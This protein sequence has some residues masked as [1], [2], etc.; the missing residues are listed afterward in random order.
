[1]PTEQ[2]SFLESLR[3]KQRLL[4]FIAWVLYSCLRFTW[5]IT[6]I[7]PE[8]LKTRL[9][10]K[11][12]TLFAHWHG[13]ELVLLSCIKPYRI[14]T[15]VSSS[16]DGAIMATVVRLLG[17]RAVRGS[18]TR[19]AISGTLGLV[20]NLRHEQRNCSLAVDGPKGPLHRA[21]SGVFEISRLLKA[22]PIFPGGAYCDRAWHFPKS[23]N[24]T[25]LPKPFAHVVIVWG[26]PIFVSAE[27]DPRSEKLRHQ[28]ENAL[29]NSRE[30]ARKKIAALDP[31]V[32]A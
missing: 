18:S 32:L 11:E 26:E 24:Q 31:S 12:S 25:F 27:D 15:L 14:T 17:G 6:F 2:L 21:K 20:R 13:D 4:G 7:E 28:L 9:R 19:G 3:L 22:V 1:M 30:I 23:W 5:R 8:S 16:K 29:H 10:S